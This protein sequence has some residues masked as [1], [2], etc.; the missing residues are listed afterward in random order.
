MLQV[1]DRVLSSHSTDTLFFL[2]LITIIAL[3]LLAALETTRTQVMQRAGAW[4]EQKLAPESFVR[5]IEGKLQGRRYRMEILRDLSVVRSFMASPTL[6]NIY[7]VPW[8]PVYLAVIF[9]LHPVL[10]GV[11]ALGAAALVLLTVVNE[12]A[13]TS[14]LKKTSLRGAIAQRQ[15]E[16]I[17]RNAEVIDAMG[18]MPAVLERWHHAS[19]AVVPDQKA[20]ADRAS[21]IMAVTKFTRLLLQVGVLGVGALLVL[22]NEMTSGAMI[23][24]SIIM[25]RAL[26]P[27]EQLIGGWKVLVSAR[28]AR[29]RLVAALME[30][31]MRPAGLPLPAPEGKLTVDRVSYAFPGQKNFTIKAISFAL[32]EGESLAV[33]GPS[34]A[35]KTTLIRLLIG[36]V[37]PTGGCVRLDGADIYTWQ[38][39]DLGRYIGYMPQDVELFDGTVFDNIARMQSDISPEDVFEAARLAGCHEMILR[40]PDGYET[41]IGEGGSHLS[42]GQRQMLGLARALF[43]KPKLV[44]LDEPNSNLDTEGE[45]ALMAAM[46]TLKARKTTVVVVSHRPTLVQRVDTILVIRDGALDMYGPRPEIM[47][48]LMGPRAAEGSP[49]PPRPGGEGYAPGSTDSR[50]AAQ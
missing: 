39:E 43:G 46:A 3:L 23:A 12:T 16:S 18:M 38:R 27:V 8:V 5:A 11:A 7:D 14:L 30:P 32:A 2:T 40:L 6:M 24:A 47:K 41:Q 49:P 19:V 37:D 22:R 35:G 31:R 34:A 33:I 13:T 45:A 17:V 4:L 21:A 28:S 44:I 50:K 29:Q 10:G 42:G 48:R 36:A 15:G 26:A 9:L 20:A 1:Y 25:G